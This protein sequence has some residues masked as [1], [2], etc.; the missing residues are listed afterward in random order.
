MSDLGYKKQVLVFELCTY[1]FDMFYTENNF[2]DKC[3]K[4]YK[5]SIMEIL[6]TVRL[7]V[8]CRTKKIKLI[9]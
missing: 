1:D 4:G 9:D 2:L 5:K 6:I 7:E 3:K 8:F